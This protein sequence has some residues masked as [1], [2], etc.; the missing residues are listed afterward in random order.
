MGQSLGVI[1]AQFLLNGGFLPYFRVLE[2]GKEL[3][4]PPFTKQVAG[5]RKHGLGR[6]ADLWMIWGALYSCG[7]HV[8][9]LQ[10]SCVLNGNNNVR[11]VMQN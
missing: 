10:F 8:F 4:T 2:W 1:E 7:T 5:Q 9:E 3:E 6:G 11:F